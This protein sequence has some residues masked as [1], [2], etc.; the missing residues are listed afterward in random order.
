MRSFIL[1]ASLAL[2]AC[3]TA[4]AQ[5]GEPAPAQQN[6]AAATASPV[7]AAL[8]DASGA[9]LDPAD[10][11]AG[12]YNLDPRHASVIWRVRHTGVG[13][14]VARFDQTAAVLNFDPQQPE[15][16]TLSV[17]IQANS[18]S[19]GLRGANGELSFDHQIAQVLG[20]DAHPE[21]TFE[22]KSVTRTGPT[23]G[24]VAGDLT[25]NGQTHPA[26]LEVNF[27]GGR[28]VQLRGKHVL[29]FSART[30][31]DRKQWDVES[32]IFNRFAGDEVEI[33]VE[34]EFVKA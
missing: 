32:L 33:I 11:P 14:Y 18:V 28:F 21:I 8:P 6:A 17:T 24:L 7:P 3:A 19:T 30:I 23:T 31:I 5:P 1:A 2:A 34:G 20:A 10:A 25:L 4:Q 15:A 16:S 26:T 27:H 13:I 22:S 9:S 12:T 29:A